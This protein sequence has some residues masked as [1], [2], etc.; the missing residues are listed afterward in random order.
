MM[1]RSKKKNKASVCCKSQARWLGNAHHLPLGG[2]TARLVIGNDW[3]GVAAVAHPRNSIPCHA[4]TNMLPSIGCCRPHR[5]I[6][7]NIVVFA[8]AGNAPSL[9]R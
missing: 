6:G 1:A 5:E 4:D 9:A 3:S 8:I 7:V 2:S